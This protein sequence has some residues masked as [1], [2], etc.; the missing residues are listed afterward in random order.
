M[1]EGF[2]T[3]A[4]H[5]GQEPDSLT[6]A[7]V[8]PIYAV[9][10]YKQDGVGGLRGGYEYSRSANPTRTALESCLAALEG[11][12]RGLAFASGLAAEDTLLRTVCRPGDHV[13]IPD[14]AYGGTYRLFAKV[15]ERWGL[16][17]DPV[18]L[19]D[20]EAVRAAMRPETKVIWVETP[21][22]PLLGIADIER[23][24][25]IAHDGGALLVVDN[26][27][28]SPY[29]QQPL[30]LGADVVVHSTT[31]YVGGHSDVI[32]GA[33]VARDVALGEELTYH[34]NAMGAVAGPFDAWL[35]LR[36]VK[37]LGVRMDRH[38]DNAER[39]VDLL[40]SHP[41]VI[42]VFYPGI[43]RHP[44]HEIAAKQMKRFGGMVSFRVA[45]GEQAAVDVCDRARLFT[46]GESLGGVE[47]L[48]EHPG[49]MTHA[50]AA[51]SPLE[52][53]A[54]LVRL[55]VGIETVGDLLDDLSQALG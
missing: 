44:G 10:T 11:G 43:E 18:P 8:P 6:G 39:V 28:A 50:S 34:Q 25:A 38:C 23:L 15:L 13:I 21:T 45:G 32:G 36:G 26:T 42:E 33:L 41:K 2:E 12:V 35:T 40:L 24:A 7:V 16:A 19:G 17:Y 9:S 46:L 55:S 37:T 1:T 53:P 22:N 31:K 47:S 20:A 3:L 4:I 51:G 14:D 30:A 29:L 49:R 48:I 52:V 27:F 5:A 54:D